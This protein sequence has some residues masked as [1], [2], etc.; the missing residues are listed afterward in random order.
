MTLNYKNISSEYMD[1]FVDLNNKNTPAVNALSKEEMTDLVAQSEL[2]LIAFNNLD[3]PLGGVV[4]FD[5][6]S[7]YDSQN[8]KWFQE[9]HNDFLYIDRIIVDENALGQGVGAG[10]Y[11][12]IFQHAEHMNL[13]AVT[14]E[15]NEI[16]PNPESMAFHDKM[17][18][19]QIASR[20]NPDHG[21]QIAMMYY[22]M[23][24][25]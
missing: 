7:D 23:K 6:H 20:F 15:V 12:K 1:W 21:K 24:M 3:M 18:F 5:E 11:Q 4:T 16:P 17:G 9:N 10:L 25:N 22:D 13:S 14:C 2:S 8:Y 19:K